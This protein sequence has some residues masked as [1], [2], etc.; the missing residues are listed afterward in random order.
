[1]L[2]LLLCSLL[3]SQCAGFV[4]PQ[5]LRQQH[6]LQSNVRNSAVFMSSDASLQSRRSAVQSMVQSITAAAVGSGAAPAL[7][8]EKPPTK[9]LEE[10]ITSVER[11]R[12]SCAQ[13]QDSIEKGEYGDLK[14]LIKSLIRNYKVQ[15]ALAPVY[16]FDSIAYISI[17]CR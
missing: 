10:C 13:L 14:V 1:M 11:V 5:Q 4:Q 2:L 16:L 12:Q 3:L 17:A 8:A 6:V 15:S 7:A 9:T